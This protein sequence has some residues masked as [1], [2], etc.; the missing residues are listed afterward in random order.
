MDPPMGSPENPMT[1]G[2]VAE[3]FEGL[4]EKVIE[5]DGIDAMIGMIENLEGIEN[6]RTLTRLLE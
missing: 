3:K 5:R 1:F 6:I 4:T 2:Q